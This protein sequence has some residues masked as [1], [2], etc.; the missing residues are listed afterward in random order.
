MNIK[1]ATD[2]VRIRPEKSEV[3]RLYADNT[4]AKLLMEWKPKFEG[5]SGF[6]EG[7]KR[8]IEWFRNPAN[9]GMYKSGIYNI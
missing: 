3:E 4:K 8:T 2:D 6:E 5:L 9:T 7:L 1:V